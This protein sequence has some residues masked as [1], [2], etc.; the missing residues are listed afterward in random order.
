MSR[1]FHYES[2]EEW[3]ARREAGIR[4]RSRRHQ[5][6]RDKAWRGTNWYQEEVDKD[7]R[8]YEEMMWQ[9]RVDDK[10]E[11]REE[12]ERKKAKRERA[13]RAERLHAQWAETESA[14]TD[15][16]KWVKA[17]GGEREHKRAKTYR[18][19][20]GERAHTE[21]A[22]RETARTAWEEQAKADRARA[23]WEKAQR[24]REEM[25]KAERERAEK[26]WA[27]R[28]ERARQR[29][30]FERARAEKARAE[31][32]RAE[33]EREQ[34]ERANSEKAKAEKERAQREASAAKPKANLPH[35]VLLGLE[36]NCSEK[37]I[38]SA[39]RRLALEHH[40]DKNGGCKK[41]EEIFKKVRSDLTLF[42]HR[43][44]LLKQILN[45]YEIL[46]D[47]VSRKMYDATS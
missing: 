44:L 36:R 41:S 38:T 35:Y 6:A 26:E 23:E 17:N 40:P 1:Q 39:Y 47:S 9:K 22:K 25:A 33:R 27:D 13:E 10:R 18:E 31:R 30:N 15:W 21:W 12:R 5:N 14:R 19:E 11:E 16:E 34:R 4:P 43:S 32:E 28:L 2:L 37:D 7:E 42:F 20:R 45:A 8:E 46:S 24:A 29:E 3:L